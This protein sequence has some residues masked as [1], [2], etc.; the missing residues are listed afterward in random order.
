MV[1]RALVFKS[2]EKCT[3]RLTAR[4]TRDYIYLFILFWLYSHEHKF[5]IFLKG[6]LKNVSIY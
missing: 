2:T 5:T 3:K 4:N 1:N 6:K